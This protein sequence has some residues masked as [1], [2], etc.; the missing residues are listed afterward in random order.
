MARKFQKLVNEKNNIKKQNKTWIF[1]WFV[2]FMVIFDTSSGVLIKLS[3]SLNNS[4]YLIFG[5]ILFTL[6]GFLFFILLHYN[7][8]LFVSS[9]WSIMGVILLFI[10]NKFYFKEKYSRKQEIGLALGLFSI[11]LLG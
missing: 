10:T 4:E 7:G 9:V 8:Y 2:I 1:W 11:F 5:I 3:K 6:A